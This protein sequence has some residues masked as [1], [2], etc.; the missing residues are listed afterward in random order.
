MI[1]AVSKIAMM[2]YPKVLVQNEQVKTKNIG[3]YSI[4]PGYVS[5]DLTDNKGPM[6]IDQGAKAALNLIENDV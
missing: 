2:V 6:T 5:T 1:Y 3:C 4:Y